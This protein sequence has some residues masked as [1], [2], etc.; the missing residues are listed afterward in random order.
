MTHMYVYSLLGP[1]LQSKHKVNA[2]GV[3]VLSGVWHFVTP[4]TVA[5]CQGSS[6]HGISQARILEWAT[7]SFSRESSQP[8]DQ[9]H[10]CCIGR[11]VLYH[12][13]AREGLHMHYCILNYKHNVIQHIFKTFSS[14]MT[15]TLYTLNSYFPFSLFSSPWQPLAPGKTTLNPL[16]TSP[17]P[18]ATL[19]FHEFD[20]FRFLM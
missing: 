3:C 16:A 17:T 15:E 5:P 14:C 4:W 18:L 12:W 2:S 13:A 6:I 11:W 20:Y 19:C 7:I 1:L 8:R 9:T 10:V